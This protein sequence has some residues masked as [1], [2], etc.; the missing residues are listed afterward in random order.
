MKRAGLLCVTA[1]IALVTQLLWAGSASADHRPWPDF[2]Q[3]P[4]RGTHSFCF[5]STS[6]MDTATRNRARY[7]MG[8]N[9]GLMW[10]TVITTSEVACGAHTDVE[11]RQR[12]AGGALADAFCL[13]LNANNRCDR[14]RIRV[15]VAYISALSNAD[16][17]GVRHSI[18]H[19]IGH[20][21]GL[22]HYGHGD[23][24]YAPADFN[25]NNNCMRSGLHDGGQSW[26][27][28]YGT[29]DRVAINANW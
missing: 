19:E 28:S 7:A 6:P 12:A 9:D 17:Y 26:T 5:S 8:N 25:G 1:A 2:V 16:A 21:V 27:R 23:P 20:T 11:F 13:A 3:E 22:W 24:Y 18:C 10:Q 15:D 4:D 14:W 29:H